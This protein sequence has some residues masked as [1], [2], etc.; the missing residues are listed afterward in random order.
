MNIYTLLRHDYV[1]ALTNDCSH[2]DFRHFVLHFT[3]DELHDYESYK[4]L[5][6][7]Q[8]KILR[9]NLKGILFKVSHVL[10]ELDE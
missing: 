10:G 5:T 6:V 7:E 2:A 8:L 3:C 1:S 4:D 9:R